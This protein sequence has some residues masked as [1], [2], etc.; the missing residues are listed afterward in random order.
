M[1]S[2]GYPGDLRKTF[3]DKIFDLLKHSGEKL[4]CPIGTLPVGVELKDIVK[5]GLFLAPDG[6]GKFVAADNATRALY[7]VFTAH[8]EDILRQ[9]AVADDFPGEFRSDTPTGLVGTIEGCWPEEVLFIGDRN[10]DADDNPATD[11][12]N[13]ITLASYAANTPLTVFRGRLCP[14]AAGERVIG[15]VVAP[16]DAGARGLGANAIVAKIDV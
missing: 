9:V 4:P 5:D 6:D 7:M 1:I 15:Y 16:S 3:N 2:F 14:A 8:T 10:L 13:V 12:G 11:V